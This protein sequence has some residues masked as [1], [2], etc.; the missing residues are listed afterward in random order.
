MLHQ[1]FEYCSNPYEQALRLTYN[2]LDFK[3]A[4][5]K[6]LAYLIMEEFS[7]WLNN[8]NNKISHLLTI[9]IKIS[10]F[11]VVRQQR[12][13]V[14]MK[15]VSSVYKMVEDCDIFLECINVMI[16]QKQYKEVSAF[17]FVYFE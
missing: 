5:P 13:F 2:C 8:V 9:Q 15:L 17:W 1:H 4:K 14:L 6:T 10:A 11:N 3:D 16:T 12:S 7:D